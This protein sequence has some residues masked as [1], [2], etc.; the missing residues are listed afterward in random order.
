MSGSP[1]EMRGKGG[2]GA[3][4]LEAASRPT[5]SWHFSQRYALSP[6]SQSPF[7]NSLRLS[8]RVLDLTG[9]DRERKD[10]SLS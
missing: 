1:S 9:R 2:R 4:M 8:W 5:F 7:T 6:S 10:S 3:A